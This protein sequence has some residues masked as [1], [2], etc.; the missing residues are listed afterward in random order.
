MESEAA[1]ASDAYDELYVSPTCFIQTAE[2]RVS[3]RRLG[4]VGIVSWGLLDLVVEQFGAL[5]LGLGPLASIVRRDSEH[6]TFFVAQ[7]ICFPGFGL[8]WV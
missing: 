1:A 8:F 3:A 2:S 6:S 7:L 5:G 4:V